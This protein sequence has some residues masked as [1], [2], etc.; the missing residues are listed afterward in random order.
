MAIQVTRTY[1]G[2]IQN[3]QQVQSDLDSLGDAAS[4]SGTL[5]GGLLIGFGKRPMKFPMK[6]HSKPT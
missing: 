1:V 4:K 3:H 5:H 6:A 2:D